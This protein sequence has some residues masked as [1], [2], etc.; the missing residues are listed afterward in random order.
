LQSIEVL[1]IGSEGKDGLA[2]RLARM[3]H[4]VVCAGP[5]GEPPRGRSWD[6][7][8]I[9]DGGGRDPLALAGR[10]PAVDGPMMVVGE[11]PRRVS[12][13]GPVVFCFR[14][15]SDAGYSRAV[16]MCAAL[17]PKRARGADCHDA[18]RGPLSGSS[19]QGA[20]SSRREAHA[21]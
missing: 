12:G 3:G 15:E 10:L 14:D 20:P 7:V 1:V 19:W 2:A 13:I 17:A 9:D 21:A 4:R 8:A 11:D 16:H 5:T 6:V 18:P